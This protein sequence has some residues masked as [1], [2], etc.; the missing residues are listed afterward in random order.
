MSDADLVAMLNAHRGGFNEALGLTFVRASATEVVGEI[1]TGPAH[2]QP[3]G[4]LHG[5][6]HCALAETLASTGAAIVAM[7]DGKHV[8]GLENTTSF[9]RACR[10][11]VLRGTARP[12]VTG[13]RSQVWEVEIREGERLV[14]Q[15]RVRALVLE[16]DAE[17]AGRRVGF[18]SG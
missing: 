3:Y 8:V 9:L 16:P 10:G 2:T 12:L 4:I 14:A 7:A 15:S 18:E 17:L 1:A 6:V 11:G 13:R 5:G